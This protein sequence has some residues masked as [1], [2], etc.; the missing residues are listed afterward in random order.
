MGLSCDSEKPT[1]L[2][3]RFMPEFWLFQVDSQVH[4]WVGGVKTHKL[5]GRSI[6]DDTLEGALFQFLPWA[7]VCVVMP[8][9]SFTTCSA[10]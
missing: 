2:N 9:V 8:L 1:F 4:A 7:L 5:R 3:I 10:M 6:T